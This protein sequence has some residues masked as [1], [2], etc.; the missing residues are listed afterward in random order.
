MAVRAVF[1]F[2]LVVAVGCGE[3]TR[4]PVSST[5]GLSDLDKVRSAEVSILFVGN[6]H[7]SS[8]DVP[9]LVCKMT[10]FRHSDKVVYSHYIP[11]AFLEDLANYPS[12]KEE[13]E[14]RPWKFV[15]LQAQKISMSGKFRY[16]Q[17]EGIAFAKLAKTKGATVLFFSEWGRRDVPGDG[18]TQEK[19]YQEMADASDARVSPIGLAWDLA[20]G[21]RPDLPLY[22]SDGNH[23]SET[24]AFLTACVL[25][26][27][28]TGE[29]PKVLVSFPYPAVRRRRPQV[30][31][32][33]R[34]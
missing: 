25:F 23:E 1:A 32:A 10:Q 29:D 22:A 30:A 2:V 20:L 7:T 14:T 11:V 19:I 31:C 16:S 5:G 12:S 13:L 21:E 18:V 33:L 27:Q 24:G 9:G 8:H 26:G 28:I 17:D 34:G 4:V 3:P 6:S 15:V